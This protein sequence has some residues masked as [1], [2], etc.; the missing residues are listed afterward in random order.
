MIALR[1]LA[2]TAAIGAGIIALA[3]L[4]RGQYPRVLA[5]YWQGQ[6]ETVPDHQARALLGQIGGLGD[7]GIP[8]LV[9]AL[10]SQRESVARAAKRA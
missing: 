3:A 7:P 10:G 1:R 6:L 8:V 2:L 9:E 4:L 5:S